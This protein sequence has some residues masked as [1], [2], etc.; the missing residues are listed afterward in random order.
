MVM[1]PCH[2]VVI[3]MDLGR[4]KWWGDTYSHHLG[5]QCKPQVCVCGGGGGVGGGG[6]GSFYG[7]GGF[8]LC[9][10]AVLKLY[11]RSYWADTVKDFI[12][13]LFSLYCCCFTCFVSIEVSKSKSAI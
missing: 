10:T 8:L 2:R 1:V 9:N 6:G 4:A 5:C 11:F 12:G 7:E 3:F 13:Y